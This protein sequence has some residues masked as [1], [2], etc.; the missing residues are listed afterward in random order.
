MRVGGGE[1]YLIGPVCGPLLW[2]QNGNSK[3]KSNLQKH[4]FIIPGSAS[5]QSRGV[6]SASLFSF[7]L[8]PG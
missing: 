4:A 7:S 2:W 6:I 8:F 1:I 3:E 5:T